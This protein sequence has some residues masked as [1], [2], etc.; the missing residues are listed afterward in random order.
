MEQNQDDHD[1]RITHPVR[2]IPMLMFPVFNHIFFLHL[3]KF[4]TKIIR[5][6]INL[7]NFSL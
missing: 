4:L 5:H 1:F 6:T 7:R 2:L 3:S